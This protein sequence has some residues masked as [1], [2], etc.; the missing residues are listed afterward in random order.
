MTNMAGPSKEGYGS[1]RTVFP[2]LM[3]QAYSGATEKNHAPYSRISDPRF[4]PGNSRIRNRGANCCAFIS[5]QMVDENKKIRKKN[6]D[7]I[8]WG[9]HVI[10][11]GG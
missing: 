3:I 1:I 5:V 7:A 6:G 4:E 10:Y 2:M 11:N 9:C 8:P